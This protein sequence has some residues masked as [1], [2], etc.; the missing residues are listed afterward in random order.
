M[1]R[2]LVVSLESGKIQK[3]FGRFFAKR[4]YKSKKLFYNSFMLQ[5]IVA[6]DL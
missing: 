5:N 3:D 2:P 4:V 6:I 1:L